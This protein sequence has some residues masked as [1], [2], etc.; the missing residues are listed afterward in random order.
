MLVRVLTRRDLLPALVLL[1]LSLVG[2]TVAGLAPRDP[3]GQVAVIAPPWY[4]FDETA[5][6]V[7]GV[8]GAIVEEGGFGNVLIAQS[9]EPGFVR[10]LYGA[11]AWLVLDP[12]VL[13]GCGIVPAART[14]AR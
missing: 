8:E 14:V 10:R 1:L 4:G 6:L 13:R 7:A 3:S 12:M 11:G 2:V 5:A 9:T